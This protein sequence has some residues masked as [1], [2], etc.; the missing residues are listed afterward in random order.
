MRKVFYFR[1]WLVGRFDVC[2]PIESNQIKEIQELYRIT[3]AHIESI[4]PTLSNLET[5]EEQRDMYPSFFKIE[6]ALYVD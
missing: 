5:E 3:C 1:S 2:S 6:Y 4:K